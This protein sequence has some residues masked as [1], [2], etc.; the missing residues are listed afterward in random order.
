MAV[1]VGSDPVQP[2]RDSK[3]E[4]ERGRNK[5]GDGER[6]EKEK[7]EGRKKGGKVEAKLDCLERGDHWRQAGR[8]LLYRIQR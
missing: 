4:R 7:L 6:K 3:R 8:I 2:E 5:E 1:F